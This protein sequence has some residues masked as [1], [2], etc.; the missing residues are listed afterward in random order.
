MW[1]KKKEKKE[2]IYKMKG[3]KWCQVSNMWEVYGGFLHSQLPLSPHFYYTWHSHQYS[4]C[5]ITRHLS[6][7]FFFKIKTLMELSHWMQWDPFSLRQLK[8]LFFFVGKIKEFNVF[9]CFITLFS[10]SFFFF[11]KVILNVRFYVWKQPSLVLLFLK[12]RSYFIFKSFFIEYHCL[13]SSN[14]NMNY[15]L[16][17]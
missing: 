6:S 9:C 17:N 3:K 4:A 2:K 11:Q 5:L 12:G 15:E 1:K 8:P 10:F 13:L 14:D 16:W 7:I